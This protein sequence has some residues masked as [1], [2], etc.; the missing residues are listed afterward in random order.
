[1]ER[2]D[3]LQ[4]LFE[5]RTVAVVGAS[6]NPAKVGGLVVANL[7]QAGYQGQIFPVNPHGG[8][9]QDLPVVTDIGQLPHGV[10][11]A[12]L[13]LPRDKVLDSLARLADVGVRAVAVVSAGF[14]EVGR[15]GYYLEERCAQLCRDRGL[16]LLGPNSLGLLNT[17]V[18]LNAT[19]AAGVPEAGSLGFFSQSGSLCVAMLDMARSRR[20]GFSS[21]ASLGNKAQLDETDML[22][23]MKDDPRTRV[24][25]GY[26]ENIRDGQGFLRAAQEATIEKPVIMIK[27]GATPAGARAASCHTG[28]AV[29]SEDACQAAFTQSGI[30]R[31]TGL[32][33][34]LNLALAFST[35]PLPQGPNVC[36]LTNSG[37]PGILAA[38]A[39][40][41]SLLNMAPLR[42]ATVE[43]LSASLPSYA[44]LYNP[45][46]ILG[47]A[48]AAR[49]DASLATVLSDTLV[50]MVLVLFTPSPYVDPVAV[51]RAVAAR[52]RGC[53]KPVVASFLGEDAVAQA[54]E[55]LRQAEIPCY[56]GP[57][58]AV[59]ALE[60]L[61]RHAEWKKRPLP[62]EICYMS[63]TFQA[64]DVLDKA[65]A[66][67]FS[68]LVEFQALDMLRAYGLS[69]PRTM[70]ARTSDEAA[71]AARSVGYPVALKIASPQIHHK[72]DIGGIVLGIENEA[73]LRQAFLSVTNKARRYKDAY[74][75]GC[76]V[77]QMAPRNARE[78]YAQFKRDPQFGP[79]V[80]FGLGGDSLALMRDTST[81]LAPLALL[82]VGEMVRE[83]KSYPILRGVRGEE[84]VDFRALEDVLL[85]LSQI[86]VDFPALEECEFN[87]IMAHPGGVMVVDARFILG[88]PKA[89]QG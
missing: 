73:E 30:I 4:A 37:G 80:S 35:Q 84:P 21:F 15:E 81:R 89:H 64:Q 62:V 16:I 85:T 87:P 10:D 7:L 69:T 48:D 59:A 39:A 17:A 86:A 1:M 56:N 54:R 66:K 61:Y 68:E 57:E 36:V 8:K 25:L 83:I 5:P 43:A 76:L 12:V 18:G 27:S 53:G 31:V 74:V 75:M 55:E 79:V 11:L 58:A 88:K 23:R 70:L 60:G 14:K 42:G 63:N 34:M 78:L 38:D 32:E 28:A 52:A 29:G 3:T 50:H 6:R 24:I 9:I 22:R 19:F 41:R 71:Q 20:I 77:Q 51:A 72:S 65:K 2:N 45:V 67:G 44:A 40:D 26:V 46:D 47:D 49:F 82:D 13:C 33:Q